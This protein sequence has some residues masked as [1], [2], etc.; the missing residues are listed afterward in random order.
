MTRRRGSMKMNKRYLILLAALVMAYFLCPTERVDPRFTP[1]AA[2]MLKSHNSDVE[3]EINVY[4]EEKI[5]FEIERPAPA[6]SKD[7]EELVDITADKISKEEEPAVVSVAEPLVTE[8]PTLPPV[9]PVSTE[10]KKQEDT[11]K[12]DEEKTEQK[13]E[14]ENVGGGRFLRDLDAPDPLANNKALPTLFSSLER[15]W[16]SIEEFADKLD[17]IPFH[18]S[19][20][21]RYISYPRT[22]REFAMAA[23]EDPPPAP[24]GADAIKMARE[25]GWPD[26][27][28]ARH[29][30][31]LFILGPPKSGTTF[32]EG[33]FRWSM[34]GNDSMLL[35]PPT[36]ARWPAK[37]GPGNEPIT[38]S[39]PALRPA[40]FWNRTGARRWDAPKELWIYPE[41]GKF[42]HTIR[43]AHQ[44]LRLPPIEEESANWV[45]MD[46]T[47]DSI[48]IPQSAQAMARDL[49]DAPFDPTFL[50][51]QRDPLAR[52]Y[53]HYLLFSCSLR[54]F[55]KWK[56]E[57]VRVFSVRLELQ[58]KTLES[59]PICHEMLYQP[60][61]VL[62]DLNKVT[63]ALMR[64][65]YEPRERDIPMYLPFGFTAL[66]LKYWLTKF[67]KERFN[68]MKME[69]LRK[70][71]SPDKLWTFFETTFPGMK[72]MKPRC[73]KPRDWASPKCTGQL[74]YDKGM[75][76][77]GKDSP[78][79]K[80][81]AWSGREGLKFTKGDPED[82]K[83][84]DV[85]GKRWTALYDEMVADLG[86]S[87][88]SIDDNS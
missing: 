44:P 57:K 49:K 76:F 23:L 79:L 29:R 87:F 41:M 45:L 85:I 82:L 13:S 61:E 10:I 22:P 64:C 37:R 39:G 48:M 34:S 81:E 83:K 36:N 84:F 72:R 2:E 8:E 3:R 4:L 62:K 58:L 51:M 86:K 11:V 20:V 9:P 75:L 16:S 33:C 88:Y 54:P 40:K 80:K 42:G 31:Q 7:E 12:K 28:K 26:S 46:S 24:T 71:D 1:L 74:A 59:I 52:A 50:V 67:P 77:C 56:P 63:S 25:R 43:G 32:M 5:G 78:A 18:P 15:K 73:N 19:R 17:R 53:S 38:D 6:T 55:F 60:E 21:S 69:E 65:L 14:K 30:P 68:F 47:P 66:G 35:Y 70:M 27:W